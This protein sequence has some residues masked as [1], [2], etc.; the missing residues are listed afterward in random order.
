VLGKPGGFRGVLKKSMS[1]FSNQK[2]KPRELYRIP[3]HGASGTSYVSVHE[4]LHQST[5][6]LATTFSISANDNDRPGA[7]FG[8]TAIG[9][10]IGEVSSTET[11]H[12]ND[13]VTG[14]NHRRMKSHDNSIY[15]AEANK[16]ETSLVSY[17]THHPEI[18]FSPAEK[19]STLRQVGVVPGMFPERH[20]LANAARYMRFASAAYGSSVLKIM[21]IGTEMPRRRVSDDTHHELRSFAHHTRSTPSSILLSS[22][23]DPQGGTDGTGATNTGVPLVHYVSLDHESKAVVLTCR[24]TLGFEDVLTDM[25]CEYDDLIWRGTSYK[26]HKGVHASARRLLYGGDGR[27]LYTLKAALEEF[28]AYGLVLTG[29]SLGGAVTSVLG[30]MLATPGR[31]TG[32][33][34]VTSAEPH[35]NL[36]KNHICLPPNRPVHVYAYGP[37]STI[38]TPLRTATRGLITTIVNGN[39]L[40]P[41]LSLGT[42]HD[43]QGAAAALKPDAKTTTPSL[44]TKLAHKMWTSTVTDAIA[45]LTRPRG[46][47]TQPATKPDDDDEEAAWAHATLTTIRANMTAE[48]LVPPGEVF[49]VE[50]TRVLRRDAFLAREQQKQNHF[51]RPAR[52]MVLRYVGD[53]E[54]RFGEVRFGGGMLGD[55]S[56][57]GYE[58]G[59]E[60]LA[61][62]VGVLC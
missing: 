40:V 39:D 32:T 8:E 47:G 55:H 35:T 62:G 37:P 49:V 20:L 28:P 31:G 10:E 16:S 4:S 11:G 52:R 48:K 17:R 14:K 13:I 60:R 2:E 6:S 53:V 46:W 34:F 41:F 43:F 44:K 19:L 61:R 7:V 22:F 9:P 36:P 38:C 29:H 24:G 33:P 56:P 26:V 5:T 54:R 25:T 58:K 59:L 57:G 50:S 12:G 1:V 42:L 18:M 15:R 45:G 3:K 21:A 27:V 23:V 51:G 30:I